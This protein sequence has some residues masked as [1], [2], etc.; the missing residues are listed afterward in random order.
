MNGY[1]LRS[2]TKPQHQLPEDIL[3]SDTCPH[4]YPSTSG[5]AATRLSN[6]SSVVSSD[7]L[8]TVLSAFYAKMI[9]IMGI[10][11]PLAEVISHRIPM[12]Y[13]EISINPPYRY[14][15]RRRCDQISQP[16]AVVLQGFYLYL[17]IG[18]ISFLVYLYIFLLRPKNSSPS[19]VRSLLKKVASLR[20]SPSAASLEQPPALPPVY[21]SKR[22]LENGHHCGSFYLRLGAVA[23]G[24]G[25][26]IYSGLEFGQFFELEADS[27]CYNILYGLTPSSRMLFTFIQLYFIFLNTRVTINRHT[28]FARFGMMHIIATNLC[29][30]LHVLVQETK[31]QILTLINL[32]TTSLIPAFVLEAK[33]LKDKAASNEE[34]LG[35]WG[36]AEHL[37]MDEI[38]S[39]HL[40]RRSIDHTVYISHECRRSNIMGALVQDASQFLFPCTIEYSLI[41]AAILYVMWKHIGQSPAGANAD[42]S[43][44]SFGSS[45]QRHYYQVDCAKA[46][47]GLFTGILVLVFSIISLIIFFVLI[48]KPQYKELAVLEAH[49]AELALYV[50]T[51]IAVFIALYQVKEL[52]YSAHRTVELDNILLIVGQSG[53]YLFTMFSVIGGHFT[54]DQNTVLVLLTGIAGIIQGTLQTIFILNA[55]CRYAATAAQARRKPGRE[56]VT[57]LLV[58]NFAMWAINTL[59]TRRADSNPVQMRFYG[60]WAWT[61]I[62][63]VTTPLT[64]FFRFH[65]TV[66]LCDI[67][68]KTYKVRSEFV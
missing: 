27:H 44:V 21:P 45:K 30:W 31:H 16:A 65:S 7:A 35:G 53:L 13:Y 28:A 47:K 46:N 14:Q 11:F 48:N 22:K 49:V 33:N 5:L 15:G 57:F 40:D 1:G 9:I 20:L 3:S 42:N 6:H 58:C 17:Y 64:I 4:V 34:L 25:S 26:M 19:Y 2:V 55:S 61:I 52:R 60:F 32:N 36:V 23:F 66:C 12:S 37:T 24:I 67:W 39:H 68:K 62:T 56:M 51:S 18:S 29:V 50:C 10:S 63:H 38:P 41:C 59:E 43:G 8:I 54:M